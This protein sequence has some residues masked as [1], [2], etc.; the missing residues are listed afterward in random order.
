MNFCNAI[1]SSAVLTGIMAAGFIAPAAADSVAM[2]RPVQAGDVTYISGGIGS[3]DQQALKAEAKNYN[4]A[5]TSSDKTGDFAASTDLVIT[6]KQ[7]HEM[8][9]VDSAGP[10]FYA[11]LP[12][13]DYTIEATNGT[14]HETRKVKVSTGKQA[15]V[16]LIWQES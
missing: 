11:R 8:I 1:I 9:R 15:D 2:M 3:D 16:H 12:A 10:L 5:I 13:G 4:L 7:G 6:G 14:Q